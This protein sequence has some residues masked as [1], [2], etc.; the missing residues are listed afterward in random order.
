M[1]KA[2]T[3]FLNEFRE[4]NLIARHFRSSTKI[5]TGLSF[6]TRDRNVKRSIET[7]FEIFNVFHFTQVLTTWKSCDFSSFTTFTTW[8]PEVFKHR[9]KLTIIADLTG[10]SIIDK[11]ILMFGHHIMEILFCLHLRKI[12][13]VDIE[14]TTLGCPRETIDYRSIFQNTKLIQRLN[15]FMEIS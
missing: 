4:F 5:K 3:K 14:D 13:Y 11:L 10:A 8:K 2:S 7:L 15:C 6:H 9:H 12:T 1:T